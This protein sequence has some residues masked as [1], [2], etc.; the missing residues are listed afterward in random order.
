MLECFAEVTE[1][2]VIRLFQSI[3]FRR[4]LR[5]A[6]AFTKSTGY[7]SAFCV[8]RD[9]FRGSCYVSRMLAGTAENI[10]TDNRTYRGELA[11][12]DFGEQDVSNKRC[13]RFFD[14][15]FHPD[16][17]NCPVPSYPDLLGAQTSLE[18]WDD[19]Q[20]DVRPIIAVSHI[21]G[22]DK[23]VILLYQKVV[24]SDIER[25]L[26]CQKI[27]YDLPTV[28]FIHPQDV[29]DY[30]QQSGLFRADILRFEKRYAYRPDRADY[31]KLKRYVHTPHRGSIMSRRLW[32]SYIEP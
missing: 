30:L 21:L 6:A 18:P 24:E 5:Q 11:D 1:D 4:S 12:F 31:S 9:F 2:D 10:E 8:A 16:I 13:Y 15:H 7:E 20:I 25:T 19:G 23:L 32:C 14:L 26:A 17:S 3:P 27:K 29:V 28:T 22:D